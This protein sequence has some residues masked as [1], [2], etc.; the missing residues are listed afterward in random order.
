[1]QVISERH[2][3]PIQYAFEQCLTLQSRSFITL[4]LL[5]HHNVLSAANGAAAA[6][7]IHS[8]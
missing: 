1:M 6:A 5:V 7:D 3:I 2:G 4:L 8:L